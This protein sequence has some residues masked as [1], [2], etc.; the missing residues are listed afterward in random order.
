MIKN[1]VKV[2]Q[3]IKHIKDHAAEIDKNKDYKVKSYR[4]TYI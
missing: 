2:F 4:N 1:Q 3:D